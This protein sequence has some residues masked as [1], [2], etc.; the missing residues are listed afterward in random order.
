[1]SAHAHAH[2]KHRGTARFDVP[3][4]KSEISS[5]ARMQIHVDVL[6]KSCVRACAVTMFGKAPEIA[7]G[8]SRG[9]A[10]QGTTPYV[11]L[12]ALPLPPLA[13]LDVY[14][15]DEWSDIEPR[16]MV[17]IEFRQ[18]DEVEVG[19]L[20]LHHRRRRFLQHDVSTCGSGR[21]RPQ[22]TAGRGST[23]CVSQ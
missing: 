16:A 10:D 13:M 22:A 7:V 23:G 1:M 11:Q 15:K 2:A 12:S 19:E 4:P 14:N 17:V 21:V 3:N 20:Y 9:W 8:L 5:P 18:N 6:T